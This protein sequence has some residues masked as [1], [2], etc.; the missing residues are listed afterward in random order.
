[1]S[2]ISP[3][4]ASSP[5]GHCALCGRHG[6]YTK[7]MVPSTK[8]LQTNFGNFNLRQNLTCSNYGIYVTTCQLC[9]N[10]YVGQTKNIFSTRWNS[11]RKNWKNFDFLFKSDKAALLKHFYEQHRSF[12]LNKPDI[13]ECFFVVFV[14]QPSVMN[15]DVCEDKWA[16]LIRANLNIKKNNMPESY[17]IALCYTCIF[18]SE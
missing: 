9:N 16:S 13:A 6:K 18:L 4:G 15:L 2:D 1:M 8:V 14:E 17:V 3:G 10:Q 7:S 5:C 11:H 12:S